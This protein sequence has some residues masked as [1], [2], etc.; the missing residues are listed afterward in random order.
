MAESETLEVTLTKP[1]GMVLEENISNFGGLRVKEIKDGGSA[2][3]THSYA[4]R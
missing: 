1:L 2:Q 3:V 4:H